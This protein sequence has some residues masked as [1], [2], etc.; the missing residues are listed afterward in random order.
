M[1]VRK[2]MTSHES[3]SAEQTVI[4]RMAFVE[5]LAR[6]FPLGK[7]LHDRQVSDFHGFN[8]Y[9]RDW[10]FAKYFHVLG[11]M[12]FFIIF[13]SIILIIEIVLYLTYISKELYIFFT[14]LF[15]DLGAISSP[16]VCLVLFCNSKP[17]LRL[18]QILSYILVSALMMCSFYALSFFHSLLFV[19][20]SRNP[21]GLHRHTV[22]VFFYLCSFL[23]S[24]RT[25]C[26]SKAYL[27]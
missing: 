26:I 5:I 25:S 12:L 18:C 16:I 8:E 24:E 14:P 11:L 13:S 20:R 15:V 10:Y 22:A 17:R 3:P 1:T 4:Y 6:K 2:K 21:Q 9:K 27:D 19:A 7:P 23:K